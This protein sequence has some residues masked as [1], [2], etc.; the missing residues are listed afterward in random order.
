MDT[1]R[2]IGYWLKNLTRKRFFFW[3]ALLFLNILL[4]LPQTIFY[5]GTV[6]LLPL[7]PVQGPR[8]WYDTLLFFLRRE[9]QDFF[10]LMVEYLTIISVMFL[11]IRISYRKSIFFLLLSCYF[12]L[13]IY[14]IY[15][16]IMILVFGESP[17]LYNDL[18]LLKGAF[19][20]LVD[21]T[22]TG[23]LLPMLGIIFLLLLIFSLIP[24][25]FNTLAIGLEI[26]RNNWRVIYAGAGL[27]GFVLI[28]TIWFGFTDYRPVVQWISPKIVK[29]VK[30]SLDLK[31]L[32]KSVQKST[33]DSSYF[34]YEYL[35]LRK[36]PNIFL[37]MVESYGKILLDRDEIK[38]AYLSFIAGMEDSLRKKNWHMASNFSLSPIFGGRSWLSMGTLLTGTLIKD[39]AIYSYFINRVKNFPHLIHFLNAQGYHTFALQPLNRIRPGYTLT[40]YEKFYQYK[41]YIN[42]ED[43]DFDGPAFGFRNIPDQYSLNYAYE[44]YLRSATP[45]LFLFF[46]TVSSHS[47]WIDLPPYLED[48]RNMKDQSRQRLVQKYSRTENKLRES[49]LSHFSG[50]IGLQEYLQHMI[51][52]LRFI[53]DFIL[54][55]LSENSLVIIIGDHQP[56]ITIDP[57]PDFR[58]P[59]HI[60]S[61]DENLIRSFED[62]GFTSGL[63]LNGDRT[64]GIRHEGFYSLLVHVLSSNDMGKDAAPGYLENGIPLSIGH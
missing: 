62:F 34:S 60:I 42:F 30:T 15:D 22:F 1:I 39:E 57:D 63:V 29:N 13:F 24:F 55:K 59:L 5:S 32:L 23:K 9:N 17:I 2:K 21:I 25:F 33:I 35:Q 46:L 45:P 14:Q 51:Y 49:F 31:N 27:W 43:L 8:G 64:A 44:K 6:Q 58:T 28:L 53:Q 12:F 52:E 18:L 40:S 54:D 7:P 48:W 20:L 61:Q 4:F 47:P 16:A 36:K 26:W 19:Y 3:F 56:P 37:L 41:T 38:P 10:R 11:S 50:G